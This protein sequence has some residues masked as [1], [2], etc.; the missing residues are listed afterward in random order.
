VEDRTVPVKLTLPNQ[1]VER[2][3]ARAKEDDRTVSAMV[4][5]AVRDYLVQSPT[6]G[7]LG[8]GGEGPGVERVPLK[9]TLPASLLDQLKARAD[10]E[11]RTVSAIVRRSLRIYLRGG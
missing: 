6:T 7:P 9:V 5:R 4:R 3:K 11:D 1:L 8:S 2:V 10:E